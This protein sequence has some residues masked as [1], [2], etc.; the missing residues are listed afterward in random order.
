MYEQCGVLMRRPDGSKSMA[1]PEELSEWGKK[2]GKEG[3]LIGGP[4]AQAN[5]EVQH[6]S[7]GVL[8]GKGAEQRLQ[9]REE[10]AAAGRKGQEIRQAKLGIKGVVIKNE[11]GEQVAPTT[12]W[13]RQK[14][15]ESLAKKPAGE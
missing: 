12:E 4:I 10:N 13:R 3:G 7:K 1:T 14:K 6:G 5:R 11:E 2:G 15:L 9:N 8:V